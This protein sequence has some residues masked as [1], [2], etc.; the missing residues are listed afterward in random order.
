[1]SDRLTRLFKNLNQQQ[2]FMTCSL[3]YTQNTER[4][5]LGVTTRKS[6]PFTRWIILRKYEGVFVFVMFPRHTWKMQAVKT[7]PGKIQAVLMIWMVVKK[8][9]Q[10]AWR[11]MIMFSFHLGCLGETVLTLHKSLSRGEYFLLHPRG[12][13]S[14]NTIQCTLDMLRSL[15]RYSSWKTQP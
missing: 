14:E 10:G 1:M 13:F 2:F 5:Q 9:A 6:Q 15:S 3:S 12:K 8:R 11:V 4:T 7:L